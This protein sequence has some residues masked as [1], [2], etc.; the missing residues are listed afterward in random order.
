ME[1]IAVYCRNQTRPVNLLCAQNVAG[2]QTAS[3]TLGFKQSNR[4][5]MALLVKNKLSMGNSTK[6]IKI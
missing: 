1:I 4:S 3:V 5:E 2:L 6:Q